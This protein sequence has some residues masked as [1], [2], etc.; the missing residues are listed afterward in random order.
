MAAHK[1]DMITPAPGPRT[2]IRDG[3]PVGRIR[4]GG[5]PTKRET[6]QIACPHCGDV[7][8]RTADQTET[9]RFYCHACGK[10]SYEPTEE[11]RAA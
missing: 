11:Q 8:W 6:K 2:P 10:L 1:W 5:E 7:Q 9:G 4:V 3:I